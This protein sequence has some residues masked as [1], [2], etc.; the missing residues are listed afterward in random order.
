LAN[1]W[2]IDSHGYVVATMNYSKYYLHRFIMNVV[3]RNVYVNHIN[4]NKLDNRRS[5]LRLCNHR[6]NLNNR[7]KNKN[8]TSGYKGVYWHKINEN[9]VARIQVNDRYI[10]LGS[11]DNIAATEYFGQFAYLNEV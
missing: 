11:Y 5:N 4:G 1:G 10:S 7:P 2:C 9:W 6:D 8:N 3:D